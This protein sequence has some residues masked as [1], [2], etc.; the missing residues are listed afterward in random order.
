MSVGGLICVK[1]KMF[2]PQVVKSARVMKKACLPQPLIIELEKDQGSS[3]GKITIGPPVKGDLC[4][5][6]G[7][8][9]VGCSTAM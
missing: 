6:F 4:P 7:K 3:N 8:N 5:T 9:I 2:L 1:V